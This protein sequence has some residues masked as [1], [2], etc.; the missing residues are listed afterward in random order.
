MPLACWPLALGCYRKA[1]GGL[2]TAEIGFKFQAGHPVG[3]E[4][5]V[6]YGLGVVGGHAG[7]TSLAPLA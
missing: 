5:I 3:M 4:R 1:S 2:A 7:L 6:E